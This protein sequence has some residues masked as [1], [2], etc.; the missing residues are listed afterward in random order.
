MEITK[1]QLYSANQGKG[2]RFTTYIGSS[3]KVTNLT[4]GKKRGRFCLTSRALLPLLVFLFLFLA[5]LLPAASLFRIRPLL[6]FCNSRIAKRAISKVSLSA[7]CPQRTK[8][9]AVT[10]FFFALFSPASRL[11]RRPTITT[12]TVARKYI[13]SNNHNLGD[14]SKCCVFRRGCHHSCRH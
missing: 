13:Y 8:T 3:A 4:L 2:L 12:T 1:L 10:F 6:G 9:V 11:L 14:A 7:R 5:F